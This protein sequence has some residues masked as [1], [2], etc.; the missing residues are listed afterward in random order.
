MISEKNSLK[1]KKATD[2]KYDMQAYL[3]TQLRKL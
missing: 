2:C 1:N 3:Y